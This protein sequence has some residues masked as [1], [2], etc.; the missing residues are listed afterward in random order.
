MA[1]PKK[2]FSKLYDQNIDKIYRF[3]FFKVSSRE[4]AEDLCAE[5]FTKG[6]QSFKENHRDIDNPRAFLYQ[7]ARNLIVDH[8][9]DKNKAEFVSFD[10]VPVSDPNADIKEKSETNSDLRNIKKALQNIKED[11]QEVVVMRYLNDLKIPEIAKSLDKSEGA[12]RVQLHRALK[13]LRTELNRNELNT[14]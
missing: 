4:I 3:I 7:I 13:A 14:D 11:Y 8:Y 6:W 9:R 1:N 5:T 10:S 2:L 12:V